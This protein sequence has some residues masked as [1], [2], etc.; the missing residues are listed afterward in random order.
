MFSLPQERDPKNTAELN[1]EIN[2]RKKKKL[3]ETQI[4]F[5]EKISKTD[6]FLVKLIKKK[7]EKAQINKIRNEKEVTTD[8][9]ENENR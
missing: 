6:K 1:R 7:K 4:W 3:N 9:T 5:F 8:T 2:Q